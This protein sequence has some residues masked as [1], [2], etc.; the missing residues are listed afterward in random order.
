MTTFTGDGDVLNGGAGNDRLE[1]GGGGDTYI[2]EAGHGQDVIYDYI[3]WI[4]MTGADTIEFDGGIL[5]D[6]VIFSKSD[7]NLVITY[8]SG[9]DSI[10]IEKFFSDLTY[11][12]IENF[13][14]SDDSVLT[15]S[16]VMTLIY[17]TAPILGTSGNDT[18]TGN[19]GNNIIN[20]LAGNDSIDGGQGHDVL[21]GGDGNDTLVG[22]SGDDIFVASNGGDIIDEA[23]G[24]NDTI[25]FGLGITTEDLTITRVYETSVFQ[26]MLI[27]WG[28]GN[29]IFIDHFYSGLDDY[30][31][32]NIA[33]EDNSVISLTDVAPVTYGTSGNDT[34]YGEWDSNYTND[35][36][37]IY[38]LAGNDILN[39]NEGEDQLFGGDGNDTLFS[40]EGN[41]ILDG[42]AGDDLLQGAEGADTYIFTGGNDIIQ[43]GFANTGDNEIDRIVMN[44]PVTAGD[45]T[46]SRLGSTTNMLIGV[47][48]YGSIEIKSQFDGNQNFKI[49]KIVFEDLSE[50]TL[51]GIHVVTQG[52]SGIDNINGDAANA[53]ID[54]IM[55][56]HDGNDSLDGKGGD[57]IIYGGDGNDTISVTSGG[58]N[59]LYGEAGNDE[60]TGSSGS[61]LLSGGDGD[62]ELDGN[63][64][65][66]TM[67]G[68]LGDDIYYVD[69]SS[70]IIVE[71]ASEGTDIVY[72]SASYTMS[73][74]IENGTIS[75]GSTVNLTGNGLANVLTGGSGNNILTGGGGADTLIGGSGHDT[76]IIDPLDTITELSSQGTDTVQADFTYTLGSN[77]ENLTL[78]GTAAVNGTG[79]SVANVL[80][81]NSND[82]VLSG[83]GGNDTLN[84][85]DG[86]D[87]LDG[88]SGN[89]AMSGGV[90]DDIYIVDTTSDSTNENTGEGTDTVQSSLTWTLASHVE[91]LTL[92]GSSAINGTGNS[93]NNYLIGNSGNNILTGGLGID[94]LAGAAGDDT[95]YV[96]NIADVII[97]NSAEGTDLVSSS[98]HYTLSANV[99]NLTL[100]GSSSDI[101]GTGNS[102]NNTITGSTGDNILD[103]GTGADTLI[104]GSGNDTYI[105]DD[106]GDTLTEGSSAGTDTVQSSLTWTLATNFENLTLTGSANINGTGTSGNNIIT[107]NSGINTL[108]G[109][110]GNDTYIIQNAAAVIVENS[111]EGTDVVQASV[112]YVLS[113]N[114]ETLTLTG[115]ANIDA[116]GNGSNN[117]LNGN[118]GNNILDGGAGNDSMFGGAGNDTYI[119]DS[120]SDNVTE[121]AN[122]GNDLVRSAVTW[123]L[124]SNVE[125]LILTGISAINGTGNT[126]DNVLSGN[127]GNNTLRG[128]SG[129]DTYVYTAGLDI[130]DEQASGGTEKLI[131]SSGVTIN[132][133]S[134]SQS[135]N[136][137]KVIITASTNEITINNHHAVATTSQI[138][139]IA[140]DDGFETTFTDH[141]TWTWGSSGG[142]TITGTSG[143]NTIIGKAGNDTLSGAAGDDD[144][145]G[146][147]GNDNLSGGDGADLLHG[148]VGDD[149]LSGGDGLDTLFGGTGED[150]FIFESISSYNNIDVIKDFSIAQD[151]VLDLG[152]LLSSY[153]P[154]TDAIED[155][156]SLSDSGANSILSV[157]RDGTGSTYGFQQI[158]TLEGVTGLSNEAALVTSG[159]LVIA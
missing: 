81:G 118:A 67:L 111:S 89:D 56:G 47:S 102:L 82:N 60:I 66:D 13:K 49:E 128:G 14:F 93:L 6:D 8:T 87:T 26:H 129:N 32:E 17:G 50:L 15:S 36:N 12:R 37:I 137:A 34:I 77:L 133:I 107:G 158:A 96:D 91:N 76:Y 19:A 142:D 16:D 21:D 150:V 70:D 78:I 4:T 126:L 54:D 140:F 98:V 121:T 151:D 41:D 22:G 143:H 95:Y 86:N 144:I 146:G 40:D 99:E 131:V 101:N 74:N 35:N 136:H 132:D 80:T 109:G 29:S 39:G 25:Q 75:S 112:S 97:E 65:I 59:Y 42:G 152:D 103:G 33:F 2:F 106:A 84:G 123:T 90:G 154:L 62:D 48:I 85:G 117:T 116:T 69:N 157:D 5:Q 71:N 55:Y 108:T 159:N 148:G 113:S 10:T 155:F 72:N 30:I 79:N 18:I 130:V 23:N 104:G 138:E 119:V 53:H 139:R 43:E 105:V 134:T 7:R 9:T 135:G 120:S 88:G 57:N 149:T 156:V 125:Y 1:G 61:D 122:N 58:Q 63:S 73:D 24:G 115:T 27:E 38:G 44:V 92:T 46:F 52:T 68:G 153:N 124:G 114:I 145:H 147:S 3:K 83:D 11:W 141:L 31:I 100:T 127:S 45:L 94:T 51:T 28:D 110:A 64:G 20:G